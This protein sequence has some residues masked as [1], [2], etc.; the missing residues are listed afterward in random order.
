VLPRSRATE[1]LREQSSPAAGDESG[2]AAARAPR[3][4]SSSPTQPSVS[5][6][7]S[8]ARP[9]ETQAYARAR[10][11]ENLSPRQLAFL[12]LLAAA[13]NV[14]EACREL[15]L[16]RKTPYRWRE[17]SPDFAAAWVDAEEMAGDS[18]EREAWRRAAGVFGHADAD[19]PRG[20]AARADSLSLLPRR[21]RCGS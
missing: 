9:T 14:S 20:A 5:L 6:R 4:L 19:A 3:R 7:R 21:R 18:L 8:S 1:Y 13:G 15:G 2:I 17:E 10:W 11:G 16:G 12:I